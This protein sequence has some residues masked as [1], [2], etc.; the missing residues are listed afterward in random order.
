MEEPRALAAFDDQIVDWT[1]VDG[2]DCGRGCG[3]QY[4]SARWRV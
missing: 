2:H 4:E 3:P 1:A